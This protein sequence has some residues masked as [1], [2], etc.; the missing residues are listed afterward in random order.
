MCA[1]NNNKGFLEIPAVSIYNGKIVIAHE[2][3][4]ETLT[5]DNKIPDTLDLLEIITENY[6]TLYMIDVN[7][8][9][10]NK[11]QL[12]FLK[13]IIDFCEVWLDAGISETEY[14]YDPLI[15]GAQEII[16]SSKTL[17]SL[18]ELARAFE[19]SENIVF[20]MDY[21]NGIIS[22]SIQIRDM[23][24]AKLGEEIKDI[25]ISKVIFADFSRI[26]K[27]KS[28]ET[29]IIKKLLDQEFK[30]YVGGGIKLRDMSTLRSLLVSG[31][32]IELIDVLKYG[33]VDF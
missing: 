7:G 3:K 28:I 11:P 29:A 6:G 17:G 27:E 32:I 22:P 13:K 33:K 19:L 2:G 5:I 8:L 20:E 16:L 12:D 30:V 24:P 18:M 14:I 9:L 26:Q 15:A 10:E 31:A 1:F 21:D 25:G 23:T 4:Y